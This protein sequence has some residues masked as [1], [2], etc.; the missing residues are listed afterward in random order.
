MSSKN[1]NIE[2]LE[3]PKWETLPYIYLTPKEIYDID[4]SD[5]IETLRVE[6]IVVVYD[7]SK[8][9]LAKF[10]YGKYKYDRKIGKGVVQ[11]TSLIKKRLNLAKS[12]VKLIAIMHS[13]AN[14]GITIKKVIAYVGRFIN[15]HSPML[16]NLE[17]AR[18]ELTKFITLLFESVKKYIPKN[19]EIGQAR[20]GLS[21]ITAYAK[22]SAVIDFLCV[23][24]SVNIIELT[25]GMKLVNGGKAQGKEKTT[26]ISED[27]LAQ[28]FNFY[29]TMFRETS[30]IVLKNEMLPKKISFINSTHWFL[31]TPLFMHTK[32]QTMSTSE[33]WNYADGTNY[34]REHLDKMK[35][36]PLSNGK[37]NNRCSDVE[38]SFIKQNLEWSAT[39]QAM[40]SAA[41]KA[42][43]MQFCILTG[44][45]DAVI[46]AI[47]FNANFEITKKHQDFKE[48]KYRANGKEVCFSIQSEFISDFKL[49]IKLRG[50]ILEKYDASHFKY[51]FFTFKKGNKNSVSRL[52]LN[53]SAGSQARVKL[54]NRA[55]FTL[56]TGQKLRV[57]KGLWVRKGFGE[58]VSAYVLQHRTSTSMTTYSGNN[59]IDTSKEFTD[60]FEWLNE[61]VLNQD[62]SIKTE[63]GACAS[64][65]EPDFAENTPVDFQNCGKGEGCLF[66]SKFRLHKDEADL[67]KLFSL[68]FLVTQCITAAANNEHFES[69]YRPLIVRIDSLV[70]ELIKQE[71]DLKVMVDAV[72]K[73]VFENE[74]LTPYWLRKYETLIDLGVL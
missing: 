36:F 42:Y 23:H 43:F 7:D 40:A 63:T 8:E 13:N 39:K 49:Y 64:G 27:E 58:V 20:V 24:M 33:T 11:K 3:S 34:T 38:E 72:E 21:P 48:I 66:C 5:N 14:R 16:N 62:F 52:P 31:P 30:N 50:Y 17:V 46:A 1:I 74:K 25:R 69:V 45:N 51:L 9:R 32:P 44:M 55:P 18:H 10:C 19:K 37:W 53:G 47:P 61:M 6:N 22:Q 56:N 73:S 2:V 15:S 70:G 54:S 65:Y 67:R 26:P 59:D 28:E 71:P 41:L 29:T 68:K 4:I 12:I 60:Y 57:T 35:D